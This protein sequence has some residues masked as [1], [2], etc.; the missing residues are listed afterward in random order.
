MP[1]SSGRQLEQPLGLR[2]RPARPARWPS[3]YRNGHSAQSWSRVG[4]T[5]V[6]GRR[7]ADTVAD[8]GHVAVPA[9]QRARRAGAHRLEAG[10][11]RRAGAT[12][13][14]RRPGRR[15]PRANASTTPR[16]CSTTL[17]AVVVRADPGGERR[18]RVEPVG[19]VEPGEVAAEDALAGQRGRGLEQV[20]RRQPL[21]TGPQVAPRRAE[22]AVAGAGRERGEVAAP[23]VLERRPRAPRAR[24]R[25]RADGPCRR[26]ARPR[27][28]APGRAPRPGPTTTTASRSR[29][30]AA[31]IGAH[32]TPSPK[33][34]TRPDGAA[35]SAS[36]AR[37]ERAR[38]RGSSTASRSASRSS[39]AEHGVERVRAPPR[40]IG[41][42]RAR[43]P[44]VS[45]ERGL[46][47]LGP[48]AATRPRPRS[49]RA[50]RAAPATN[51]ASSPR[52]VRHR[53]DRARRGRASAARVVARRGRG[54][55]RGSAISAAYR[56]R[57]A[58]SR[59]RRPRRHDARSGP[60]G[61]PGPDGRRRRRIGALARNAMTSSRRERRSRPCRSRRAR[62][63]PGDRVGEAAD[64]WSVVREPGGG[65]HRV[66]GAGV[67]LDRRHEDRGAVHAHAVG[68][69][70]RS[71]RRVTARISSSTSDSADHLGAG[72]RRGPR[73]TRPR[74]PTGRTRPAPAR[75]RIGSPVSPTIHAVGR[76]AATAPTRSCSA[77][78][79]GCGQVRRR[80][81]RAPPPPDAVLAR[82]RRARDRPACPRR[83]TRR[84]GCRTAVEQLDERLRASRARRAGCASSVA[85]TGTRQLRVATRE[86][87][88]RRRVL[89]DRAEEPGSARSS[90]RIAATSTGS[91]IGASPAAAARGR[92]PAAPRART[93]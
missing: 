25:P 93:A 80:P 19:R 55:G 87:R 53:P 33:R 21:A 63:R 54:R 50:A 76:A 15:R 30:I 20:A 9:G 90:T 28:A 56:S 61:R 72:R 37:G 17:A 10:R 2:P 45:S 52:R 62:V 40:A 23:L 42:G 75:P 27:G 39:A 29:P 13:G 32:S 58:T 59:R 57:R 67:R 36:T 7:R 24:R 82:R 44:S 1:R 84:A 47:P 79:S 49:R 66:D 85:G 8:P 18:H 11:D 38:R 16:S 69:R 46:R 12:S 26:G 35:S 4:D 74:R 68:R 89:G 92:G 73:S 88:L 60:S 14:M 65:E 5:D 22:D 51:S 71:R 78:G 81:R 64:R 6:T 77:G 3:R 31:P 83:R 70:A 86:R 34:P 43:R 48:V 91:V 41:A